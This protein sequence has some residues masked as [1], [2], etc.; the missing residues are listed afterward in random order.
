MKTAHMKQK[1][2]VSVIAGMIVIPGSAVTAHAADDTGGEHTGMPAAGIESVV[3]ESYQ[4]NVKE[5]L[6]LYLVPSNEG[7]Y[8]NI[9]F[10]NVSDG[11]TYI[12]SAPDENSDW[13]GKM[14][15]D[16][17]VTV[18]EY[19]GDWAKIKSGSA[20]GYVPLDALYTGEE[21]KVHDQEYKKTEAVV[22]ADVLNVRAGQGTDSQILTQVTANQTYE[23]TG[24]PVSNWYPV[25][26]EGTAGWVSGEYINI[27][28]S[29]ASAK[30]R[31]EEEARLAE[32][33]AQA[34]QSQAA[35]Q[36]ESDA[37]AQEADTDAAASAASA[38]AASAD[39]PDAQDKVQ[40][41]AQET[42]AMSAGVA[43]TSSSGQAVIDYACQFIGNPYVW[44]GTS[45][46]EGADC[47]GFVQS[48]YAHFGV[49]LPRTTWDMENVGTAV[50]YD[51][52]MPGD[53]VL[54][55]GHVGLYMGDG[56][57]VNAMNEADGIGICSATYTNI[58]TIR[59]VL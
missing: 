55:D 26:V 49:S 57:I 14:Y 4:K 35:A 46:T 21:A 6:D 2:M 13:T 29:Y 24:E 50:S 8:L 15:S 34:A 27:E 44:G 19:S 54:Y 23:V 10:S 38:A 5:R 28:T 48:V 25:D 11:F 45:L 33:A 42:A 51:Q 37:A 1:L 59:R 39:R 12:R 9:A 17:T 41:A 53:I 18:L 40:T 20:E 36:T 22:E 16:T 32:E 7:E 3:A 30:S 56:N 43:G 31:A 47:S 52:A 58:I